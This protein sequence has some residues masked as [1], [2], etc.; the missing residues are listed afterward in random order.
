MLWR[1]DEQRLNDEQY[2][3]RK[4]SLNDNSSANAKCSVA[5]SILLTVLEVSDC[6]ENLRLS[7]FEY[8][9]EVLNSIRCLLSRT[10]P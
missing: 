6:F 7:K 9:I 5:S 10:I 2:G 4:Y 8:V 1:L 3:D